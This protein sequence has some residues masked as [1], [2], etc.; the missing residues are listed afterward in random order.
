MKIRDTLS[1]RKQGVSFEVFPPKTEDG[2]QSIVRLVKD[3]SVFDPL[4]VSV[5]YGAGGTSRDG[6][7]LLLK[8]LSEQ[9]GVSLMSHLTC[10]GESREAMD[11]TLRQLQLIGID[12]IL[13]LRGDEPRSLPGFN[14]TRGEFEYARD[15]VE[16]IRKYRSF[17]IAV[18]VYPEGHRQ[19]P[20]IDK[21]MEY[22][23]RKI[24]A[25]AEAAITQMFFDNRYYYE[26]RERCAKAGITIPIIPGIMPITD[27]RKMVQFAS[28]CGSTITREILD[29][30]EPVQ[31][32]PED[33]RKLGVE[34]A[35]NQSEDLI[36]NGVRYLHFY[37]MNRQD[38]MLEIL[39]TIGPALEK[40]AA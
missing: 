30:L 20:S 10:I 12:N 2:R 29:R 17:S 28:I 6:T 8:L 36:R 23:K 1:R 19:S 37:T 24:D 13:A 16:F 34:F 22:T 15:F 21:D 32:M 3:L 38:T 9:T 27:C 39:T 25:G 11:W 5:T 4:Y 33:M 40:K 26:F 31:D 14:A 18:A 7:F 35:I